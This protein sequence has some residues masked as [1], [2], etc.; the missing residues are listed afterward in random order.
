M[1]AI[2]WLSYGHWHQSRKNCPGTLQPPPVPPDT[3]V[4]LTEPAKTPGGKE[5]GT[6]REQQQHQE[7]GTETL[8]A[9]PGCL[10][11]QA[12]AATGL[13]VPVAWCQRPGG[14]KH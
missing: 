6:S 7:L 9:I 14:A 3:E 11:G 1:A 4:A 10:T 8:G 12:G 13:V 2:K 5:R